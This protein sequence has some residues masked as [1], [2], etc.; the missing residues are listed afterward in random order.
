VTLVFVSGR[1]SLD[2]VGT[3]KW[4]R[5]ETTE[6][7]LTEPALLSDW[8]RGAG[9]VNEPLSVNSG[10]LAQAIE[11]R[12]VLYRIVC[13][14]LTGQPVDNADLDLLNSHARRQP[15]T[16]QLLP[17]GRVRRRASPLQLLASVALDTLDLLAGTDM[18]RIR[19]CSSALCTR[20]YIDTSRSRNRRWCGMTEC[21]NRA[22][23]QSFRKRHK[24]P[25]TTTSR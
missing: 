15:V 17:D 9:L 11:L 25:T 21:G 19:E 10:D 12:E 3:L 20:L 4:R 23:A 24:A 6:E 13:A 14:R 8:A 18:N 2:F 7:Q 5:G 22:K 1:P 16:A